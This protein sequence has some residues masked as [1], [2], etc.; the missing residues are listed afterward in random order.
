MPLQLT[1]EIIDRLK[2]IFFLRR[3]WFV[4]KAIGKFINDKLEIIDE[5]F[6]NGLF[7]SVIP[8]VK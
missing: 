7:L 1:D 6:P 5:H 8:S 3:P 2:R 4:C